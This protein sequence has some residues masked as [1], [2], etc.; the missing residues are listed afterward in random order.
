FHPTLPLLA[1]GSADRAVK[2]WDPIKGTRLHT[3]G[4]PTDWVY[5]VAWSPDG[6][7]LAAAGVDK[8]LRVWAVGKGEPRLV[9][10]AFA[11]QAPVWRLGY[12]AD[13]KTLFTAG[14]DRVVKGGDA[15]KLTESEVF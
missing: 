9:Q 2:V 4:E 6:K 14:E 5:A 11:H 7:H 15:A 1:S 8:S 10:S 3:L 12:A 13:G